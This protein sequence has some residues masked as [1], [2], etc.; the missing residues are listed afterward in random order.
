MTNHPAFALVARWDSSLHRAPAKRRDDTA[1][2]EEQTRSLAEYKRNTP[3]HDWLDELEQR[4]QRRKV[5]I[6]R[7]VRPGTYEYIVDG[8]LVRT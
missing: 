1:K 6:V 8:R 4:V 5:S 3:S 7:Q 2:L